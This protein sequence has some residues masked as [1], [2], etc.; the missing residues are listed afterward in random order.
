[1]EMEVKMKVMEIIKV[2]GIKAHK[3]GLFVIKVKTET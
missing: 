1:M 2:P 3:V